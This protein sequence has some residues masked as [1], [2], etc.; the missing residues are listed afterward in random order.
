MRIREVL[1]VCATLG[2]VTA[3]GAKASPSADGPS[4]AAE[5]GMLPVGDAQA[6][7]P[8]VNDAGGPP[9]YPAFTPPMPQIL[10]GGSVLLQPSVVNVS[11]ASDPLEGDIDIFAAAMGKTTYWGDRTKE[12]GIAALTVGPRIHDQTVWAATT[13]DTTIQTWL[14]GQLAGDAGLAPGWP[15]P[16]KN[17]LYVLYFPPGVTVTMQGGTSCVDFHG[18]HSNISL[19]GGQLVPYAV[20]SRCPSIPEDT[21]ATGIQY[22]SAVVSHEAT[23]AITDPFITSALNAAAMDTKPVG[24]GWAGTDPAHVAFEYVTSE[25]LMDMCTLI[26]DGTGHGAFYTPPDFPY[27]MQRGWSNLAASQWKNPCLPV[28]AGEVYFD[29][30]PVLPDSF[31]IPDIFNVA[32]PT[33]G[34]KVAVGQT[35]TVE[36]DLWSDGPMSGPWTVRALEDGTSSLDLTLDKATGQNGDKLELTVK[37]KDTKAGGAEFVLLVSTL[38]SQQGAFYPFVVLN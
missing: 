20:I 2:L 10:S 27:L 3:C 12:Y 24:L 11:F 23:E 14:T 13:D 17:T 34:V 1:G 37:V 18:Y 6:D 26:P 5:A 22:V 15:A 38:G 7:V 29:S 32:T 33:Q 35:K 31:S 16:D 30:V 19:P 8:A 9:A 25:E 4:D 36:I 21:A 28:P